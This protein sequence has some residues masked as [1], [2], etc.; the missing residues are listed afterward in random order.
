[1]RKKIELL[2]IALKNNNSTRKN[3]LLSVVAL[4]E[5]IMI[6]VV[7]T[8]AWVEAT[9]SLQIKGTGSID[10]YTYTT[11]EVGSGSGYNNKPIDLSKYFRNSGN[12]HL[13]AAS[14]A[15]GI[16]LYFPKVA[17]A[18]VSNAYR[19]S[20]IN[21][22]NVNYISFSFNVKAA[23][24]T[25][26]F[27]FNKV[28]TIKVGDKVITNNDI[29]IAVTASNTTTI[30]SNTASAGEEVIAAADGTTSSTYVKAFKDYINEDNKTRVFSVS[31]NTTQTV[32]VTLWLQSTDITAQSE[33]AGKTVTVEDFELVSGA[34]RIT[35]VDRTTGFNG[36]V[37]DT[38]RTESNGWHWIGNSNPSL[39]LFDSSSKTSY[40]MSKDA[41]DTLGTTWTARI[42]QALIDDTDKT[43]YVCRCA[44][45][46]KSVSS[47]TDTNV[48]NYW[49]LPISGSVSES[50]S[51]F[52]AYGAASSNGKVGYG[53]W[54]K[55]VEIQLDTEST[56][57]SKPSDS[58]NATQVTLS[59][60]SN[61]SVV[62]EMNYNNKEDS[63]NWLWKGFVP[64]SDSKNLKFS[65]SG[66][67]VNASNRDTSETVSKFVVTSSSTGYWNPP[68]TVKAEYASGSTSTMGTIK[69]SGGQSGA[70]SVKVTK[71]T[72]VT[73]TA[74]ASSAYEFDGWY[75]NSSGTGTKHSNNYAYTATA[76][77]TLY[78]K[79]KIKTLTVTAHAV[80]DGTSNSSTGGTVKCGSSTA[81]ATSSS[82][83]NYGSSVALTATAKSG[84]K[85]DGWYDSV[86]GGN[87]LSTSSSYTL[88][89]ITSDRNVYARF[90]TSTNTIYFCNSNSYKWSGTIYCYA[91]EDSSGS[92]NKDWPGV[93]MT[94]AGTNGY[95]ESIYK[96]TID[97]KY[98][99]VIFNNNDDQTVNINVSDILKN[100]NNGCYVN[101][102]NKSNRTVGY[103]KY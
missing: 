82:T 21:D 83:V 29:R 42:P 51:T 6:M 28:P 52:T 72:A 27:Y 48:W 22:K 10:T 102:G 55:V 75:E 46:V 90:T 54:G 57:L 16:N 85:F 40:T 96:I 63:Q 70:A 78:A 59:S 69:V 76:D 32:T 7:S 93:S 65:F 45:G 68:V 56:A 103:A 100:G 92:K 35:F 88:T 64:A 3:F 53:T 12:V 31:K 80:T 8:F 101:G 67:T 73:F 9:T 18:G 91:W 84:Y 89:A 5:V 4:V 71:N 43:L 14:S 33:Y 79:F 98:D 24:S 13:S 95:G 87:R 2:K 34:A 47:L 60:A 62:C 36:P 39:I 50:S 37:S 11:A 1:M 49:I 23:T 94:S 74:T 97:A 61:T 15:D 20:N 81:G 58:I 44:S 26:N 19:R 77:K 99:K 38:D 86:S 66:H 25:C 30:F 41:S 17:S